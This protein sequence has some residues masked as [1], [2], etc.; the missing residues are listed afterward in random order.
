M[1]LLL[2]QEITLINPF[3]AGTPFWGQNYLELV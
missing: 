3:T 1:L 2:Q